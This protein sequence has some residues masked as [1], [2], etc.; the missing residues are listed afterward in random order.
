MK[1]A[2]FIWPGY[3]E[4]SRVLKWIFERCDGAQNAVK[5]PIGHLPAPNALDLSGLNVSAPTWLNCC[6][7]IPTDGWTR[8]H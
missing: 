6:T 3:G 2:R 8:F 4:N 5:T 1:T 7:S